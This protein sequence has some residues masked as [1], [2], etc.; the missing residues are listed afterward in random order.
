MVTSPMVSFFPSQRVVRTLKSTVLLTRL[1]VS[2]PLMTC[3]SCLQVPRP[4]CLSLGLMAKGEE[5]TESSL[6]PARHG[7]AKAE[8]TD[9]TAP[10][11]F[12]LWFYFTL[13]NWVLD[14][15][16]PIAMV[17]VRLNPVSVEGT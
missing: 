1:G 2:F 14:F 6:V 3:M 16:R 9:H 15:G 11:H 12:D 10:F 7:S 17:S 5:R 8:E 4:P 13:Q